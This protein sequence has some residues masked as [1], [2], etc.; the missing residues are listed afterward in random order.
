MLKFVQ[1]RIME[2]IKKIFEEEIKVDD[3]I[4]GEEIKV[5]DPIIGEETKVDDPIIVEKLADELHR[6]EEDDWEKKAVERMMERR[7]NMTAKEK[8]EIESRMA[9]RLKDSMDDE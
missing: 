5:D 8:E 6:L 1:R 9:E 3:P 7:S 2:R 4:I